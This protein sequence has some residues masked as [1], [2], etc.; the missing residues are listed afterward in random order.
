[1]AFEPKIQV[2]NIPKTSDSFKLTDITG[3]A[4]TDDTGYQQA[5]QLPQLN[6]EWYKQVYVGKFGTIPSQVMF[7]TDG[8]EQLVEAT[9]SH[10]FEDGVHLVTAYFTKQLTGLSYT[11][12][13]GKTVLTKTNVDQWADPYGIFEGVYGLIKS[14]DEDFSLEDVAT[15]AS[16]TNTTITLNE[17]LTGASADNDLWILYKVSKYILITNEGEGSL[18][19]DIGDMAISAL[20]NGDGCSNEK[21]LQLLSRLMLKHASQIAFSCANYSKAHN[22]AVLLASKSSSVNCTTCGS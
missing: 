13:A 16:V 9:L 8:D 20:A 17:T 14:A 2:S 1:M 3:N 11:L 10:T 4:P 22:A 15:I 7:T 19:S 6:T 21:S 12:N 18:I 5:P